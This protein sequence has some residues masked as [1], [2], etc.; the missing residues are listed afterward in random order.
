MHISRY[1]LLMSNAIRIYFALFPFIR[2]DCFRV[3]DYVKT[4]CHHTHCRMIDSV[5]KCM[6]NSNENDEMAIVISN[7]RRTSRF[8]EMFGEMTTQFLNETKSLDSINVKQYIGIDKV[9]RRKCK[10]AQQ[11]DQNKAFNS[12]EY[13]IF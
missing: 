10:Y 1:Q 3:A 13:F 6:V 11:I 8:F 2:G 7:V 5:L 4:R 9:N 12:H